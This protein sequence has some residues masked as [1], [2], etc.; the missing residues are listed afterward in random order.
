MLRLIGD[1]LLPAAIGMHGPQP[2]LT[3]LCQYKSNAFSVS[4]PGRCG[5]DTTVSEFPVLTGFD[6]HRVYGIQAISF[7]GIQGVAAIG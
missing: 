3:L 5:G 4:R 2:G 7:A 6:I 1:A